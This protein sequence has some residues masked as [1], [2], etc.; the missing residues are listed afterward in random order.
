MYELTTHIGKRLIVYIDDI[1]D[2]GMLEIHVK[3]EG[4]DH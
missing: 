4:Y 2:D 3:D 1:D